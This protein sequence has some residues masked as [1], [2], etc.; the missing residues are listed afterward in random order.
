MPPRF[1]TAVSHT[2]SRIHAVDLEENRAFRPSLC[3]RQVLASEE[4]E[5]LPQETA[6]NCAV[7]C[8]RVRRRLV[9]VDDRT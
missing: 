9:G 2:G 6:T 8:R 3:F 5:F 4:Q 7:C 1:V